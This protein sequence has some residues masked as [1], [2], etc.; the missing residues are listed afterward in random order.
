MIGQTFDYYSSGRDFNDDKLIK[1]TKL[2]LHGRTKKWFKNLNPPL[3]HWTI[4]RTVIVQKFS[5]VDVN[6]IHI[7]L[8]TIK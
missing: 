3:A 6:E 5:D 8:N 4:L 2:N 1:I 7:K